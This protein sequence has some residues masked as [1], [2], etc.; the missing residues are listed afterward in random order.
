MEWMEA[1]NNAAAQYTTPPVYTSSS[2]GLNFLQPTLYYI[3][4]SWKVEQL[5]DNYNDKVRR[6]NLYRYSTI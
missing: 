4:N 6:L 1:I 5:A 3:P 2:E